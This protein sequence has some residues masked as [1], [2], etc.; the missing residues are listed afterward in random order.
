V[1]VV[2]K[3]LFNVL[4][5][6]TVMVLSL[7]V[8]VVRL[9]E[10]GVRPGLLAAGCAAVLLVL[11]FYIRGISRKNEYNLGLDGVHFDKPLPL[12]LRQEQARY[13]TWLRKEKEHEGMDPDDA[14]HYALKRASVAFIDKYGIKQKPFRGGK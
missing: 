13:Y 14:S 9:Y 5:W 7:S 2:L 3:T 12:K 1:A 6:W 4:A 8:V 10:K 11:F